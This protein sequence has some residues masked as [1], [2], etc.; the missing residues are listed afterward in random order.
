LWIFRVLSTWKRI[1]Q[2]SAVATAI[3]FINI[4]IRNPMNLGVLQLIRTIPIVFIAAFSF[5]AVLCVVLHHAEVFFHQ[6]V[7]GK[8]LM[9]IS[10]IL[11][12]MFLWPRI[13]KDF[14]W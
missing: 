11:A 13:S 3:L 14:G 1:V 12:I 2:A 5:M 8:I 9:V 7:S 4:V 10:I 6:D